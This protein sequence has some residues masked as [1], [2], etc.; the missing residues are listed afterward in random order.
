MDKLR[1]EFRSPSSLPSG[2]STGKV[3]RLRNFSVTNIS[4]L[5]CHASE[6][7]TSLIPLKK[8][9]MEKSIKWNCLPNEFCIVCVPCQKPLEFDGFPWKILHEIP[10]RIRTSSSM[11]FHFR[12]PICMKVHIHICMNKKDGNYII[13][14]INN[15]RKHTLLNLAEAIE[16]KNSVEQPNTSWVHNI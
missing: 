3:E 6:G 16:Q 9:E 2:L 15:T 1:G 7:V 8:G 5:S 4:L 13:K 14:P 11:E 10:W 12:I